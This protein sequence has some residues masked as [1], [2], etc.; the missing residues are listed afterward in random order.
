MFKELCIS[1]RKNF[2][3]NILIMLFSFFSLVLFFVLLFFTVQTRDGVETF[4]VLFENTR[5]F[6]MSDISDDFHFQSGS[7]ELALGFYEGLGKTD[8]FVHFSTRWDLMLICEIDTDECYNQGAFQTDYIGYNLLP[9][10]FLEGKGFE[11]TDFEPIYE[12]KVPVIVGHSFLEDY[13]V[14]DVFLLN[15]LGVL[16]ELEVVG[17]L[18]PSQYLFNV[19]GVGGFDNL[20]A[21]MLLPRILLEEPQTADEIRFHENQVLDKL[22]RTF[23]VEDTPEAIDIMFNTIHNAAERYG[24][25]YFMQMMDRNFFHHLEV[26][27]LINHNFPAVKTLFIS[28]SLL[29]AGI[30]FIITILKYNKRRKKYEIY[31][32][33]GLSKTQQMGILLSE[34]AIIFFISTVM[35]FYFAFFWSGLIIPTLSFAELRS[36]G[37]ISRFAFIRMVMFEDAWNRH[38]SLLPLIYYGLVLFLVAGIFPLTMILKNVKLGVKK[39]SVEKEKIYIQK[40]KSQKIK[41]IFGNICLFAVFTS[42]GFFWFFR[43]SNDELTAKSET[44]RILIEDFEFDNQQVLVWDFATNIFDETIYIFGVPEAV[45]RFHLK[46]YHYQNGIRIR[47]EVIYENIINDLK[48]GLGAIV[49]DQTSDAFR[50]S[51]LEDTQTLDFIYIYSEEW[52]NPIW[53]EGGVIVIE[54]RDITEEMVVAYRATIGSS[55]GISS[56]RKLLEMESFKLFEAAFLDYEHLII[57]TIIP[58]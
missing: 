11:Y 20:D 4:Q 6:H 17:I 48:Q 53:S 10:E 18:K 25:D 8:S 19:G 55:Y 31:D 33:L 23:I 24:I 50:I 49:F 3:V 26:S 34:N 16:F 22:W 37:L 7:A 42:I 28:S 5:T 21:Y 44:S 39:S 56:T 41:A 9:F 45:S 32:L 51:I 30:L 43:P 1:L 29:T 46:V 57:F 40:T 14:G 38:E 36:W 27:N 52:D 58:L 12:R 35:S 47:D 13:T 2:Y 54:N 15:K